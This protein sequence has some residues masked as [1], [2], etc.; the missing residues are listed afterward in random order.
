MAAISIVLL[1]TIFILHFKTIFLFGIFSGQWQGLGDVSLMYYPARFFF[2]NSL[3]IGEFPLWNKNIFLGFPIHAEGQGSFFY[4]PNILFAIFHQKIAYNYAY[5]IHLF[6]GGFFM[7]LFLREIKLKKIPSVIASFVFIFSGFFACHAEHIVLFNSCIWVPLGFLFILR[8]RYLHLSLIFALQFLTGFSQIAFY[9]GLILFFWQI[10]N[11]KKA[12]EM[13]MFFL[14]PILGMLIAFCQVLPT[15][16]LI[17]HSIRS[18]GLSPQD[19]FSWGY[20][21]KDLLLFIH[22]YFFGNPVFGTYTRKDSIFYENCIFV[23]IMAIFL[24]AIGLIKIKRE[25]IVRF[26]FILALAIIGFLMAF[27]VVIKIASTIPIFNFFR[28]PQ[29]FLVFVVFAL[30]VLVGYAFQSLT[31]KRLK[32]PILF[33][34]SLELINF[35]FGYNKVLPKDYFDTP[36]FAKLLKKDTSLFRIVTIGGSKIQIL[37]YL[38][39]TIDQTNHAAQKSFLNFLFS[40]TNIIFDI[41]TLDIYTPLKVVDDSKNWE[42]IKSNVKYVLSSVLLTN[43]RFVLCGEI[44]LPAILISLK[45][46]KNSDYF[47]YAFFED[48]KKQ[49]KEPLKILQYSNNKVRIEKDVDAAGVVTLLDYNYPGWFAFVDGISSKIYTT[50]TM[51]RLIKVGRDSKKIDFIFLPQSF[52][53][54]IWISIFAIFIVFYAMGIF[55]YGPHF[56]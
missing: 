8:K 30:S 45:V 10:F 9:T 35:G 25:K 49:K 28:V 41:P 4:P 47:S 46:Y 6:L 48:E 53:I 5:L 54:G 11:I 13:I 31:L 24:V 40:N 21:L 1:V 15:L 22:P 3:R 7:Y 39:S 27:P 16:E 2:G 44:Y 50:N 17:P 20:Y 29:R 38:F 18:K 34:I 26:F 33:I 52:I 37:N 36:N 23:G 56:S 32:I 19:M 42:L 14:S 12:K 51:T 55:K 43:D